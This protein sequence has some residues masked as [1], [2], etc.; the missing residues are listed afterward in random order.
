[1]CSDASN[2]NGHI[3]AAEASLSQFLWGERIQNTDF[4]SLLQ[5]A[6]L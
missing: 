5:S 2:I 1:M 6:E 4:L 3:V